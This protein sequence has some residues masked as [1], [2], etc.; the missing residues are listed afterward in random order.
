[1]QSLTR[2]LLEILGFLLIYLLATVTTLPLRR[3]LPQLE[4][5]AEGLLFALQALVART[6][7]PVTVLLVT[8]LALWLCRL[9]GAITSRL[10][11]LPTHAHAWV[12]FWVI[13]LSI[14]L[15]EGVARQVYL[16]RGSPF[17]I[18]ELLVSIIRTLL[19][20]AAAFAILK[21]VLDIDISPLLASTALVTAVVGFA[22]Q[23]VLSNLLAGMSLHLTRS[24]LPSDW[25]AIG[26]V[27]GRVIE[28]NWRE[29][30]LHT[31]DGHIIIVPNST[32]SAATIHNMTWPTPLRRHNFP[33]GASYSDAPGAVISALVKAASSVY[34]VL[35]DPPP[36]AFITEFKDFGINY[37]L[38]YWTQ[39]YYDRKAIEGDVARMIWYQ[40]KRQGI[41][42]PFPMSDKLLDDF[43]TVVYHQ[44]RMQPEDKEVA[45]RVQDLKGSD[46]CSRILVDAHGASMLSDDDLHEVAKRMRR[47]R[48]TRGETLFNQGDEG[49]SCYVI[50]NGRVHGRVEYED[51]A[52]AVEFDVGPG[53]LLGEMSLMTGLPRTASIF[54]H[55]EVELLEIPQDAF[56]CL[57][58]LHEEIPSVLARL[59]AERAE[60]NA[61]ALEKLKTM[62]TV[63]VAQSL[64][65]ENILQRFLRILGYSTMRQ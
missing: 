36:E 7:R 12:I 30:R 58:G 60:T 24:V 45:Q 57:L 14:N 53:A 40:F 61:A 16:F 17:P 31:N 52:Q 37:V 38:R 28:T 20:L 11:D 63:D 26:D 46:F 44:R 2:L 18:P 49:N 33:V 1:M 19:I 39:S 23:G 41:E 50:V 43:M 21:S 13:I 4:T 47:V 55:D 15:V 35:N 8:E 56:A 3:K 54:A 6:V 27:E 48:Y 25:V 42:I 22:L 65:Q 10:Q 29:T 34:E 59:V 5:R 9:N 64:R 51:A 62:Q 32:V